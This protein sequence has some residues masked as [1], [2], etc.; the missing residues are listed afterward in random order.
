[1]QNS[2]QMNST[3]SGVIFFLLCAIPVFAAIAFGG[4]DMW[5]LGIFSLAAGVIFVLWLAD[6][7]KKS[8]FN[9]NTNLLQLPLIGLILIGLI[10]LLPVGGANISGELLS[11]PATASLSID[12]SLTRFA[13]IKFVIL[14]VFFA[15]AYTFINSQKRLQKIVL[16]II[17]SGTAMAIF[18]ILQRLANPAA[19]YG[20]RP[21]GQAIPF[22]SFVNQHHFAGFMEMTLGIT[23]ALIFG[24][25]VKK[26]RQ[27]FYIFAAVIMGMAVV[28]TSSRG[29][30]ISMLGVTGLVILAVFLQKKKKI[31]T[32]DG[33]DEIESNFSRNIYLFGGGLTFIV[34]LFGSVLLLGGDQSLMRGIGLVNAQDDLT[35][36]R[37]HFWSVAL[38]I[39]KDN[40]IFGAGLDAFA[41]AFPKYDTW[42]GTF[43]VENAHNDYLQILADT[44]ILGFIC[45]LSF[46]VLFFKQSLKTIVSSLDNFRRSAA[47]GATAGCFGILLHS[48][49]DFPLR[50]TS[51][52]FFF[53]T[54]VVIATA[55]IKSRHKIRRKIGRKRSK[56]A[57]LSAK[58]LIDR[59]AAD[60]NK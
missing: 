7:W 15:A 29:G 51:N 43:R 36:G 4:V 35:G 40:P 31:K 48:F 46:I 47:I 54:L 56:N 13:V 45:V 39:F 19:I 37:T 60:Q 3:L 24:K 27:I 25:A 16:T 38:Q 30:M 44:G 18:G 49:F 52:A 10:Q 41:T 26:D 8:E 12:P 2:D 42:N 14:A 22:A 9:F 34:I 1:M 59:I 58:I 20:I 33:E 11:I 55:S 53:L 6:A 17:I 23:L 50:T 21:A 57:E 32:A 5:A 28:F